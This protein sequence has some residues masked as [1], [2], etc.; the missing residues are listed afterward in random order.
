MKKILLILLVCF[1]LYGC[2]LKKQSE[3][4]NEDNNQALPQNKEIPLNVIVPEVR[5]DDHV[6]GN[7]NATVTIIIYS[8]WQNPFAA[9][10]SGSNGSITKAK[11]EF[12]D[13]IKLIFRHYPQNNINPL[14]E[15]A[16]EVAECASEQGKFWQM[17]DLLWQNNLDNKFTIEQFLKNAEELELDLEQ[18]DNCLNTEKYKDKIK[19]AL[20]EA[21][22]IGLRAAPTIFVNDRHVIGALN[23]E[24]YKN[25]FGKQ[26]GLKSIIEGEFSSNK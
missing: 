18:F 23:Y 8:D 14:A 3:V 21:E 24:D 22:N 17:H 12:G 10:L 15:T 13:D 16:A 1:F 5:G 4:V 7:E 20:R 19:S 2:S 26:K 6:L 25:D 11:A 9:Q